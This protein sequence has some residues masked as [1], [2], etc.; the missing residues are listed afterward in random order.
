ME[1]EMLRH[2]LIIIFFFLQTQ[3]NFANRR[4]MNLILKGE[5]EK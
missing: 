2:A 3:F 4:Y 1:A 5:E